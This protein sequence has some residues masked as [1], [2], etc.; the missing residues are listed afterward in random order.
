MENNLSFDIK[1]LVSLLKDPNDKQQENES[2]EEF[3][4]VGLL[5]LTSQIDES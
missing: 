4:K 5:H 2:D 1:S 3:D